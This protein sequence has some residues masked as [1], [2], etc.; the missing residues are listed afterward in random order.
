MNEKL[1]KWLHRFF[2]VL[3]I[4]LA[5]LLAWQWLQSQPATNP[6][7][8][9]TN[10]ILTQ[11]QGKYSKKE[12]KTI[13]DAVAAEDQKGLNLNKQGY[14]A[15][16]KLSILLPIYDNAYSKV[17]LDK[18]ANTAQKNWPVPVMGQGNYTLAAHNWDNGYTGFSALQEKLKQNAPYEDENGALGKSAWLNGTV[19]YLANKNGIYRYKVTGQTAVDQNDSSVLNPDERLDNKAKLTIVTCLFPDTTKRIITH[20]KYLDHHSWQDAKSDELSHFDLKKQK[21]NVLP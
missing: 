2:G 20:A 10:R 13:R 3:T 14:I 9:N 15:I 6:F 12:R 5:L 4:V 1:R 8:K 16:P 7:K 19:I 18:G 21:T 11:K 17:A